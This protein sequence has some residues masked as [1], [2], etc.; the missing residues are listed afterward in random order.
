V[1]GS[2]KA[3]GGSCRWQSSGSAIGL[4]A[5]GSGASKP[6]TLA[7][8]NGAPWPGTT[9]LER[10]YSSRVGGREP[11]NRV[12]LYGHRTPGNPGSGV[13]SSTLARWRGLDR[14]FVDGSETDSPGCSSGVGGSRVAWPLSLLETS[15]IVFSEA[16]SSTGRL[17]SR[18]RGYSTW[19]GDDLEDAGRIAS[20][21][22]SGGTCDQGDPAAGSLSPN[23]RWGK[24]DRA[25]FSSLRR[26]R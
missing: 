9:S 15:A 16:S 11:D 21:S 17:L 20:R 2:G 10:G 8:S 6:C 4:G 13:V 5:P 19:R 18:R 25:V 23:P 3:Y 24:D 7:H 12:P 14:G 26:G 22:P 1:S